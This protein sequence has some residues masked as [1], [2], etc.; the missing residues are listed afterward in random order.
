MERGEVQRELDRVLA[1]LGSSPDDLALRQKAGFL[2]GQL[3]RPGEAVEHLSRATAAD[4]GNFLTW[5]YLGVAAGKDGNAQVIRQAADRFAELAP[6]DALGMARRG[7][8]HRLSGDPGRAV[9]CAREAL[10][11]SPDPEVRSWLWRLLESCC[12]E[13][14]DSDTPETFLEEAL[15]QDPDDTEAVMRL[16]HLRFKA[17]AK[18]SLLPQ[19][20]ALVAHRPGDPEACYALGVVA[21]RSGDWWRARDALEEAFALGYDPPTVGREL[22]S[23]LVK[24]NHPREGIPHLERAL[25]AEL[26]PPEQ[27]WV[28]GGL[29]QAYRMLHNR[30]KALEHY[31]QAVEADPSSASAQQ[32]LGATYVEAGELST[33]LPHLEAAVRLA[34]EDAGARYALGGVLSH[35]GRL[36]DAAEHLAA[37]AA[38]GHAGG[39]AIAH[40]AWVRQRQ[41]H[42]AEAARLARRALKR[43]LPKEWRFWVAEISNHP[44][45]RH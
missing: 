29:A 41:G 12:A 7:N 40:L 1:A 37:A 11:L 15:L 6:R 13:Q 16:A 23:V 42:H 19:A 38:L 30:S 20:E 36:D 17:G 39:R 10:G 44:R 24:L 45:G 25:E 5:Y 31:R 9:S 8:L 28:H 21:N 33:G 35:L 22:G 34:P 43:S 3:D 4:P 27:A 2:L 14:G 32:G 18:V 26:E